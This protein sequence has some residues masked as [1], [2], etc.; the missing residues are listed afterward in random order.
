MALPANLILIRH[1]ESEGNLAKD[2]SKAGDNSIFTKEFVDRPQARLRLTNHGIS[3]AAEA[4][5]WVRRWM[6]ANEVLHFDR[7]LVS[8]FSRA[9]E[10]AALLGI[11]NAKWYVDFNLRER[12]WGDFDFIPYNKRDQYKDSF[13][14]KDQDSFYWKPPNG[15]C[16]AE[17]CLRVDRILDTLHRECDGKNVLIVA[18]GEVMWAFR[19]RLERISPR[20]YHLLDQSKDPFSR[21]HN[22]G[23]LWYTRRSNPND[24]ESELLSRPESMYSTTPWDLT[25]SRNDWIKITRKTYSN[26]D[27]LDEVV[28]YPRILDR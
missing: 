14:R 24:R 5:E 18:H 2:A 13:L 22:C 17:L 25:L 3:Q 16:I 8:E 26:Q 11:S 12:S 6:S 1:G 21:I 7:C 23:V 28:H 19:V 4:G 9:M 20:E 27:L 10:T 15:E